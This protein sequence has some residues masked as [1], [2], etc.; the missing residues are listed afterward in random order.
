MVYIID[1]VFVPIFVTVFV[2]VFVT[3][4]VSVIVRQSE[5]SYDTWSKGLLT[6]YYCCE[7]YRR[8]A[9]VTKLRMGDHR[10]CHHRHPAWE[11][12]EPEQQMLLWERLPEQ[13]GQQ[14]VHQL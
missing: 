11:G 10:H 9:C 6:L 7:A 14:A 12:T 13:A 1:S 8:K 5:Q 3:V 4:F 2:F